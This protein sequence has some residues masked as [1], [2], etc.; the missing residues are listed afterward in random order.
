MGIIKAIRDSFLRNWRYGLLG[1]VIGITM[2]V[3]QAFAAT[4]I[5]PAVVAKIVG[6]FVQPITT[7]Y[8]YATQVQ[9]PVLTA[10]SSTTGGSLTV[11]TL[12][13]EVA[14]LTI[15]GTSSPSNEI[16]T[17]TVAGSS[18]I[19]LTWPAVPGATGYAV[20]F[21]T[22]TPGSENAYFMATSSAN[23]FYTFTSTSSPTFYPVPV[24]GAGYYSQQGSGTTT[25]DTT[26]LIRS[27]SAATTTCTTALAGAMF[28]STANSHL[29]L[30]TGGNW[31]VIK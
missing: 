15:T 30:C 31:A 10:A 19:Q 16:A 5:T 9:T 13:F 22:T 25:L 7:S 3:S 12:Y 4:N 18:R 20:Y 28:Y 2:A 27:Q 29:W 26:G 24:Q 11:G 8:S 17:T 23:T 14:A 21:G 6:L 1:A